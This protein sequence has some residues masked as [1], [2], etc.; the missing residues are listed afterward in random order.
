MGF[1]DS[2]FGEADSPE[3]FVA[4]QSE[5]AKYAREELMKIA[6]DGPPDVPL[7]QIA[8]IP[9][10]GAERTLAREKATEIAGGTDI[11]SLPE[12]QGIIH[13]VQQ[14]GNLLTN[15]LGRAMQKSG[16]FTSTPGRDVLGRAVTDVQKSLAASLA[17]FAS[18]ERRRQASMIPLLEQLGLTEETMFMGHDQSVKD[19]SYNKAVAE[20]N[21]TQNFMIPLLRSFI[22]DQPSSQLA[23]E[24]GRM[25]IIEQVS[26]GMNFASKLGGF[27]SNPM[28]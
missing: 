15:R 17:P 26:T 25:G 10:M 14:A 12:V 5:E 20:S 11:M 8:D 2:V 1:A 4:P 6:K 18:E 13:E 7:R 22:A 24:P 23:T 27:M 28:G 16:N 21:Q 3:F 19:A 9:E